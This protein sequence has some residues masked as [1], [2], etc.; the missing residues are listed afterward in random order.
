MNQPIGI[1]RIV[2]VNLG[3]DLPVWRPAIVTEHTATTIDVVLFTRGIHD[4]LLLAGAGI[5]Y[6]WGTIPLL[7]LKEGI[8]QKCWR[9]PPRS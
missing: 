5:E 8:G 2:H 7:G 6:G 3:L 9:W 4:S 1:G